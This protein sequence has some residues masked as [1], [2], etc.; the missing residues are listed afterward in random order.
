M[1]IQAEDINATI[2]CRIKKHFYIFVAV[3]VAIASIAIIYDLAI[4]FPVTITISA[5]WNDIA[6]TMAMGVNLAFAI[7]SATITV[8]ANSRYKKNK[9]PSPLLLSLMFLFLTF[10]MA[11]QVSGSITA[12]SA[13]SFFSQFFDKNAAWLFLCTSVFFQF[14]FILDIFKDGILNP[15]NKPL[16]LYFIITDIAVFVLMIFSMFNDYF[17]F[18]DKDV[19][20][21]IVIAAAAVAIL[22]LLIAFITQA[23]SSFKMRRS[24]HEAIYRRSVLFIGL[25]GICFSVAVFSEF[26]EEI[27]RNIIEDIAL[28]EAL[29][30]FSTWFSPAM[31]LAGGVLIYLGYIYPSKLKK[32]KE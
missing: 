17:G 10:A 5:F 25:S 12:I 9:K 6:N 13:P 23:N 4:N 8:D 28:R 7:I 15:K 14:L 2:V 18:L 3:L 32:E 31:S 20:E 21:I 30:D 19:Q 26:F 22:A 27:V 1:S 29:I 24:V 11:V 16:T